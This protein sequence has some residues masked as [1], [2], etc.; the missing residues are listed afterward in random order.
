MLEYPAECGPVERWSFSNIWPRQWLSDVGMWPRLADTARE[1][2]HLPPALSAC[3]GAGRAG[4]ERG[5]EGQLRGGGGAEGPLGRLREVLLVK[6]GAVWI[7]VP[8]P[9]LPHGALNGGRSSVRVRRVSQGAV[10][11]A[12]GMPNEPCTTHDRALLYP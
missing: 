10:C 11:M 3:G 5:R 8:A 9:Q 4:D 6:E 1:L 7:T 2:P 12:S